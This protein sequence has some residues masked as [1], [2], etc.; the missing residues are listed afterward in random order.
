MGCYGIG[1]SRLLGVIVEKYNDEKGIIWPNAVAPY[2]VHLVSLGD[3]ALALEKATELYDQ[4]QKAGVEILFDDRQ[5]ISAGEKF[6]DS[7]LIGIPNRI[8][9]S[10]KTIAQ[11]SVE[12]KSRNAKEVEMVPFTEI[13][14][15][16]LNV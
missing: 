16:I 6:A 10:P 15:K 4:F 12:L 3:D 11:D 7:D 14:S 9:V 2:T 13:I 5:G 1:I 8:I